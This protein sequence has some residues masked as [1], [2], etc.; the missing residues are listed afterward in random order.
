MKNLLLILFLYLL[1]LQTMA[2]GDDSFGT[3]NGGNSQASE[4]FDIG[5]QILDRLNFRKEIPLSTGKIFVVKPVV[6]LFKKTTIVVSDKQLHLDGSLVDAINYPDVNRIEFYGESWDRQSKQQK[7]QLVLHE[8][9]GL[10]RVADT[11]YKISQ[12]LM[13]L[14]YIGINWDLGYRPACKEKR[15]LPPQ[16]SDTLIN[17]ILEKPA[18]TKLTKPVSM[19]DFECRTGINLQGFDFFFCNFTPKLSEQSFER[20]IETLEE[21]GI[22]RHSVLE[23]DKLI[24]P[25]FGLNCTPNPKNGLTQCSLQAYWDTGCSKHN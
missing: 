15:T 23:R 11:Q 12:Q 20:V 22:A 25:V 7:H 9:L 3:R 17:A 14:A 24:Y 16:Q 4:F 1:P 21:I 10:A 19:G 6:E 2:G 13:N 18:R 5:V 8:I